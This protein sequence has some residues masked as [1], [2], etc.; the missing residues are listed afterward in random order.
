VTSFLKTC[1]NLYTLSIEGDWSTT[2]QA[3]DF[4]TDSHSVAQGFSV[5][6]DFLDQ[7][8]EETKIKWLYLIYLRKPEKNTTSVTFNSQREPCIRH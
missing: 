7:I 5:M 8:A 4:L 2:V 3:S 6:S 1:P